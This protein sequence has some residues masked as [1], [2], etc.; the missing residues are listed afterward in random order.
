MEWI[1]Q[2]KA[3]LGTFWIIQGVFLIA[4]GHTIVLAFGH[5]AFPY[6]DG[7]PNAGS[8]DEGEHVVQASV[9]GPNEPPLRIFKVDLAGGGAVASHLVLNAS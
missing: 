9:G 8:V 4:K 2:L 6:L 3:H 7:S 1:G 5:V